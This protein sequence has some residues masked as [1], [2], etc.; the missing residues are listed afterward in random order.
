MNELRYS[1]LI[2]W[3]AIAI[4]GVAMPAQAQT[5][6]K[7]LTINSVFSTGFYST[8]TTGEADQR[9][10]FVPIG[11]KFDVGAYLF[12]PDF[13]SVNAAPELNAGPQASEAGFQNGNGIR[14]K[15]SALRKRLFPVTLR[16]SNVQVEDVYFGS[17]S[18]V[19]AYTLKNRSKDLGVTWEFNPHN[20][21]STTIDWGVGS[22]YSKSDIALIP[23]YYSRAR[24]INIDSKYDHWGWIFQGLAHRE[25]HEADLYAPLNA[26]SFSSSLNQSV[27]QYQGSVSRNFWGD[28]GLYGSLGQQ[29]TN[30]VVFALPIDLDTQFANANLR[31]FQKRRWK[32]SLRANYSSNLST[33]YFSQILTGVISPGAIAPDPTVLTIL[34]QRISNLNGNATTSVDLWRGITT[35]GMFDR[36]EVLASNQSNPLNASYYSATGGLTYSGN[37]RWGRF[38]GQYGRDYGNGSITGQSGRIRGQTYM[39]NGQHGQPDQLLFEGSVHGSDQSVDNAVP[40]SIHNVAVEGSVTRGLAGRFRLRG[41]GGWQWGAFRNGAYEFDTGGYTARIGVDHSRAQVSAS[42]SNLLGSSL[43]IFSQLYSDIALGGL[44]I[45]T[46]RAIP[47]DYRAFSFTAH[48]NPTR[49]VE[50]SISWTRSLQHLDGFLNSDFELLDI[51]ATYRFRRVALD[52]GYIR[53]NQIFTNHPETRRERLYVRISRKARLL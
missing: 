24:H 8:S 39:A 45:P 38:S 34:N 7:P 26:G 29:T 49:K 46:L 4:S 48:S 40:V 25:S 3:G 42:I 2:V 27:S 18:Q 33:Q 16:Y 28:S 15:V 17:L 53:A 5:V 52:C 13:L 6:E 47:S 12:S 30:S 23:D 44:L 36:S 35:Y 20:L 32:S 10:A 21:P 14:L 1:V 41:G 22:V 43:P 19:S 31:L 9:V 37:F 50:I 11:A 51:H